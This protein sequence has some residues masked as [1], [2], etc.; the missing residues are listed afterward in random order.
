MR[1]MFAWLGFRQTEVAFH[2]QP[3]LAGETK[4]PLLK[5]L[6]LAANGVV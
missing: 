2:R 5:M 4:Y 6:R 3:R 1:G